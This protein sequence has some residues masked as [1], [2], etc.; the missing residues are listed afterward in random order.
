MQPVELQ[1]L[2]CPYG[3]GYLY[4]KPVSRLASP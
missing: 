3:Q 1:Q 4:S 2:G